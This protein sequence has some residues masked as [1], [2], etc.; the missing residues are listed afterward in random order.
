[1]IKKLIILILFIGCS[2]TAFAQN[3]LSIE[4][5]IPAPEGAF[6]RL[7]LTP[8]SNI[9]TSDACSQG[10]LFVHETEGFH[11]CQDNAGSGKWGNFN[12]YWTQN[13]VETM[14]PTNL[15][16]KVGIGTSTPDLDTTLTIF[17]QDPATNSPLFHVKNSTNE[18][19]V[20]SNDEGRMGVGTTN[21]GT[22]H[23]VVSKDI[24]PPA[25][26]PI[27]DDDCVEMR[28]HNRNEQESSQVVFSE[29]MQ[30]QNFHIRYHSGARTS[31]PHITDRNF[32]EFFGLPTYSTRPG[33]RQI[34]I[35][36]DYSVSS[37]Q[38]TGLMRIGYPAWDPTTAATSVSSGTVDATLEIS[39]WLDEDI[40]QFSMNN[41]D[42]ETQNM[43][44]GNT[45]FIMNGGFV[46]VQQ[47]P[48]TS[49]NLDVN[50]GLRVTDPGGST[51]PSDQK[52]KTDIEPI[53]N[54]LEKML[55]LY[56]VQFEWSDDEKNM[57]KQLGL[58]AQAVE[59]IF[60]ELVSIDEK[61]FYSV[62]YVKLIPLLVESIKELKEQN[63]KFHE[64]IE[65]L[66]K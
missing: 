60:P 19:L 22:D 10:Q 53:K 61:G 18:T 51:C 63:K 52:L 16:L 8:H 35:R 27:N 26:N 58:I 4:T 9:N 7:R 37:G 12:S 59:P 54:V 24:P 14:Y 62:D 39:N 28:I 3:I 47:R 36:R 29:G 6:D 56:G 11:F 65:A 32:L 2:H 17:D 25:S 21:L 42:Y 34:A 45:L 48:S 31:P 33:A 30:K 41:H 55:H 50:G 20:F 23:F 43:P 1:M 46:G 40:A 5:Y 13:G 44:T 38:Y 66:K 64:R 49:Y 57:G 15:S